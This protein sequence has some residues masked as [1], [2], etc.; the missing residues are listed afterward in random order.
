MQE[1]SAI[2]IDVQ[3]IWFFNEQL[4][5]TDSKTIRGLLPGRA[6]A[7]LL[8]RRAETEAGALGLAASYRLCRERL[9]LLGNG[10]DHLT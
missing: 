5:Y 3:P 9:H 4:E 7:E 1:D 6:S 2:V 8:G 10:A